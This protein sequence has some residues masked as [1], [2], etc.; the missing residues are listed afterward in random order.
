MG[1]QSK[2]K[3]LAAS[4]A[5]DAA[6]EWVMG[7]GLDRVSEKL[8]IPFERFTGPVPKSLA[9]RL[10]GKLASTAASGTIELGKGLYKI[11]N[12]E[13]RKDDA[14]KGEQLMN[15]PKWFQAGNAVLNTA[16]AISQYGA[17]MEARNKEAFDAANKQSPVD[18]KMQE[19]YARSSLAKME[20]EKTYQE[21]QDISYDR[22][23]RERNE[24]TRLEAQQ[25]GKPSGPLYGVEK[26][27]QYNQK[28]LAA[29]EKFKDNEITMNMVRAYFRN[30]A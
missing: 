9:G 21:I 22:N 28:Q 6:K 16:D 5:V 15:E 19:K 17:A 2:N 10:V 24:R 30:N 7:E 13:V 8:G 27:Q 20:N 11:A 25:S 18:Y 14:D 3:D 23:L 4:L 29:E 12:P 26:E 1:D